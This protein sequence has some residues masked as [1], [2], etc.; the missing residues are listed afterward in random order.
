MNQEFWG[1][2]QVPLGT[3]SWG[4]FTVVLIALMIFIWLTA[5]LVTRA[6]EDSDLTETDRQMLTAINDLHRKG[7]LSQQEFR[8]IKS[9]LVERLKKEQE[10][11]SLDRSDTE[12]CEELNESGTNPAVS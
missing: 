12:D 5:R 8:S 9:Q 3:E 7:D 1:L 11:A 2:P 6:T 10:S 4:V